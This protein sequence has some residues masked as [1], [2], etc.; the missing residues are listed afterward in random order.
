MASA[1]PN[2]SHTPATVASSLHNLLINDDGSCIFIA[3]QQWY[4]SH[5]KYLLADDWLSQTQNDGHLEGKALLLPVR[6][7]LSKQDCQHL[8]EQQS[9]F[10]LLG[11]DLVI[12][13]QFVMVKKLPHSLYLNDVSTAIN[14]LVKICEDKLTT[15]ADWLNWQQKQVPERYFTSQAFAEQ[16]LRIQNNPQ[17]VQRLL[18]KAVKID[19][20]NHLA[21]LDQGS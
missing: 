8:T 6:V 11:F 15:L 3:E 5:I 9:W 2:I 7:N 12:D 14:E 19:V 17:T 10:T 21:Q 13:K 18:A 4:C 20:I 1:E 16:R